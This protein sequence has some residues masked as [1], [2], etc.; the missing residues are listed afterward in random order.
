[1]HSLVYKST[2]NRNITS[3]ELTK[4]LETSRGFNEKNAISGCL[5]YYDH[6]FLQIL[7]GSKQK[8]DELFLNI[9]QDMRHYDVELMYEGFIK[10]RTFK[11]WSMAYIDLN[12]PYNNSLERELFKSNLMVYSTLVKKSDPATALFWNEVRAYLQE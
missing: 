7:E 8:L 10:E 4:I 1:M 11:K 3:K 5:I 9:K 2:A 12:S 6:K